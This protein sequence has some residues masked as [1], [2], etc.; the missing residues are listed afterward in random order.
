MFIISTC[1]IMNTTIVITS[2]HDPQNC[3]NATEGAEG[4]TTISFSNK[5]SR[6][7][8]FWIMLISCQWKSLLQ[9]SSEILRSFL[10]TIQS[11]YLV[12]VP[13][14]AAVITIVKPSLY[15]DW[16]QMKTAS[17]LSHFLRTG[18]WLLVKNTKQNLQFMIRKCFPFFPRAT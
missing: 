8:V 13:G 10:N 5:N 15:N 4:G 7:K 3:V 17:N 12:L 18:P 1:S 6:E 2:A 9:R 16:N 14:F 11:L